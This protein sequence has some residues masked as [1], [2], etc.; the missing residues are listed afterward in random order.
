MQNGYMLFKIW[1]LF[2][3]E[4]FSHS[5]FLSNSCGDT[6][7]SALNSDRVVSFPVGDGFKFLAIMFL[8][9]ICTSIKFLASMIDRV[10]HPCL[11]LII[12]AHMPS[13]LTN[14]SPV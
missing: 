4:S 7:C 6:Q 11:P 14:Q 5:R 9:L 3:H 12:C 1:C 2:S 13:T 10:L 8:V